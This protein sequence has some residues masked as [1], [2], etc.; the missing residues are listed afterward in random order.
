MSEPR[1]DR[2]YYEQVYDRSAHSRVSVHLDKH[3]VLDVRRVNGHPGDL[4]LQLGDSPAEI[5]V[6]V[7]GPELERQHDLVHEALAE[8]GHSTLGTST[9]EAYAAGWD[10]ALS[11]VQNSTGDPVPTMPPSAPIGVG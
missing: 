9:H 1:E 2:T 6:F 4:V 3:T 10:A 8:L 11:F 5:S 7:R